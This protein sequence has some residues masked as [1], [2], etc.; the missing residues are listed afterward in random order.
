M[1]WD[2][3]RNWHC[4]RLIPNRIDPNFL[5]VIPAFS[6]PAVGSPRGSLTLTSVVHVGSPDFVIGEKILEKVFPCRQRSSHLVIVGK[7]HHGLL[8]Q[9]KLYTCPLIRFKTTFLPASWSER[10]LLEVFSCYRYASTPTKGSAYKRALNNGLGL[11]SLLIKK[12]FFIKNHML[13]KKKTPGVVYMGPL[14]P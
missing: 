13:Y 11:S 8:W 12:C 7:R 9:E 1:G 3:V 4:G 14:K 6:C 5:S 2:D 10:F